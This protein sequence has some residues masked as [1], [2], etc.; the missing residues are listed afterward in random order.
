MINKNDLDIKLLCTKEELLE[1]FRDYKH[2]HDYIRVGND[3][4]Y[5]LCLELTWQQHSKPFVE[6]LYLANII[7]NQLIGKI[8]KPKKKMVEKSKEKLSFS[9]ALQMIGMIL[10]GL[11]ILYG[12]PFLIIYSLSDRFFLSLGLGSIPLVALIVFIVISN[13]DHISVHKRNIIQVISGL[14]NH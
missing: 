2:M 9:L 12:I 1:Y 7:D 8:V 3:A 13:S 11:L 14:G 10:L 6:Y 4:N 5:D